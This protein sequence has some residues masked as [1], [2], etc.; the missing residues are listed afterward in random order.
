MNILTRN[1]RFF[2]ITAINIVAV[3]WMLVALVLVAPSHAYWVEALLGM[4]LIANACCIG[5]WIAK[6]WI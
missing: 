2:K 3:V 5:F 4:L 1:A 6:E